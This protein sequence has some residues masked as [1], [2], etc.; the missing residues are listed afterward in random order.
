MAAENDG[1][2]LIHGA[3]EDDEEILIHGF[4]NIDLGVDQEPAQDYYVH[5]DIL[6]GSSDLVKGRINAHMIRQDAFD[7][8]LAP[9]FPTAL[10][11]DRDR[12]RERNGPVLRLRRALAGGIGRQKYEFWKVRRNFSLAAFETMVNGLPLGVSVRLVRMVNNDHEINVYDGR[13]AA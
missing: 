4:A 13:H 7:P 3:A 9:T 2:I 8:R 5:I 10:M 12:Q 11:D 1:E 6:H